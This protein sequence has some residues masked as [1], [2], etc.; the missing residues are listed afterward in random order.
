MEDSATNATTAS[1]PPYLWMGGPKQRGI[2]GILWFCSSTLIV[3]IWSTLHF[4]IPTR[5]Y[6]ITRRFFLQVPWMV[7]AFLAPE[8]LLFLAINEWITAGVLLK[9]VLKFHPQ[10]ARPGMLA[11]MYNWIR[12]RAKSK[13]V[14]SLKLL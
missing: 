6:T 11:H 2:L 14:S 8:V 5:R 4:S 10:L 3:C 12:G 9:K 13:D 7:L 1:D